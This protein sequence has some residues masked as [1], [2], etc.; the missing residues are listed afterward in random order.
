VNLPRNISFTYKLKGS[1]F[2]AL[3]L[4]GA[5]YPILHSVSSGDIY[6]YIN[7]ITAGLTLYPLFSHSLGVVDCL[8]CIVRQYFGCSTWPLLDTFWCPYTLRWI[9][10]TILQHNEYYLHWMMWISC[11]GFIKSWMLEYPKKCFDG[12][13]S[14]WPEHAN[15]DP[16]DH[17]S[18]SSSCRGM[19]ILNLPCHWTSITFIFHFNDSSDHTFMF[20]FM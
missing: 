16:S 19:I 20:L 1:P 14:A 10:H 18:C 8:Y 9:R 7:Y 6:R 4:A 2:I 12:N 3:A 17:P 13:F 15:D 11:K 5:W